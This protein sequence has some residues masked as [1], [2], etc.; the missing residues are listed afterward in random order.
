MK[1]VIYSRDE[2]EIQEEPMYWSNSEGWTTL[3][4][5]SFYTNEEMREYEWS[6]PLPDGIWVMSDDPFD[7]DW[8]NDFVQFARML[9][10]IN[11]TVDLPPEDWKKLEESMDLEIGDIDNIFDRAMEVFERSKERI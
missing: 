3:D 7:P 1:Y 11:S 10:E 5:A 4:Q 9:S 6:L 8:E 2:S